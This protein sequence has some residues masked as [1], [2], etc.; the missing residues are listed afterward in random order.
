M[1]PTSITSLIVPGLTSASFN[2]CSQG[3]LVLEIRS[4]TNCSSLDLL[5]DMT[6]CLGP[7]ESAVIKGKL[8]SVC[9][10]VLSSI[11]AF[12]AASRSLC[13]AIR[14]VL[15]SIL[16]SLRNSSQ[17]QSIILWSKSSPPK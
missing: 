11:F 9:V 17:I 16:C 12:S 3:V 8:I 13:K 4:E 15:R 7:D 6:K 14:S 5:K 1:P 2:A 10:V